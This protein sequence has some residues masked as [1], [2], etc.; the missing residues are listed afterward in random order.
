VA[1][2]ITIALDGDLAEAYLAGDRGPGVLLYM[3][4]FGLRP[5]IEAM[6]DRI[7]SW[8]YVVLA[9]NV[10]WRLGSVGDFAPTTDLR[11]PENRDA[12]FTTGVM[13][14]IQTLTPDLIQ[15]DADVWIDTLRSQLGTATGPMAVVGYCFGG[16]LALRAAAYRADDVAVLG[17]FHTGGIV[18]DAA[19]S[20]HL[21]TPQLRAFVLAGHADN[22]RSN[23]PEQIAAFDAALSDSGVRHATSLYPGSPHG[24]SMEDTSMYHE[25]GAERHYSEL[26][27]A[28]RSEL[29]A[30]T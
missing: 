2:H 18:T 10:F 5:Q 27:A 26:A 8:G 21:L 25:A 7:A 14:R 22:D 11:I 19:E 3:D 4:A 30:G 13:D 16:R 1:Q 29:R 17:L 12:F 9:P 15:Q 20:P 6:I 23:S 24:Y 28:L